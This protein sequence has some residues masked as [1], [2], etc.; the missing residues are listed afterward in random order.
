MVT[1]HRLVVK[2]IIALYIDR[3]GAWLLEVLRVGWT[4]SA[5]AV[6]A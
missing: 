5:R 3:L 2:F 6:T 1:E 4:A